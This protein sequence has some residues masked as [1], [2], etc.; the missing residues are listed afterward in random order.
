[1]KPIIGLTMSKGVI[2]GYHAINNYYMDA[3]FSSGGI[4]INIPIVDDENDLDKYLEILD[5][6]ILIGGADIW[7][8]LYDE[9]PIKQ[10]NIISVA[11][12]KCELNLFKKAYKRK[13]PILG[14]CKGMQIINVALGGNLYQDIDAQVS[15]ALGHKPIGIAKDELYHTINIKR[16]TKLYNIF[17][18]EE[19]YVNS[20]HH[21]SIKD[22][23]DNLIVSAISEDGIIEAIEY[24][25]ERYL[26][27][28]QFHPECLVKKHPQFL[29]LFKQLVSASKSNL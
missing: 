25:D 2:N 3:V 28:V 5:G 27:G 13:L 19:E 22:L 24:K 14:I 4:P 7:P 15:N 11:R 8:L 6:L 26:I 17:Q 23:G 20:N 16:D 10:T 1:M 29:R 12:D 18:S 9:N 21:Q